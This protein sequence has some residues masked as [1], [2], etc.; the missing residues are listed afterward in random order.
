MGPGNKY[1][2][3]MSWPRVGE[4]A[5]EYVM[6]SVLCV[7]QLWAP[8]FGAVV[9]TANVAGR[10]YRETGRFSVYEPCHKSVLRIVCRTPHWPTPTTT[11]NNLTTI[12]G[13]T[14]INLRAKLEPRHSSGG[15][16]DCA[17]PCETPTHTHNC[18]Y[19]APEYASEHTRTEV[20][21]H[22]TQANG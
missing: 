7:R 6:S 16:K 3:G 1:I 19:G 8:V 13:P 10:K 17:R 22:V 14:P 15:K 4:L 2:G 20:K 18:H 12:G 21:G 5:G 11:R 9:W